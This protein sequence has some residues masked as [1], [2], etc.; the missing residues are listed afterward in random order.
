[1][2]S[3]GEKHEPQPIPDRSVQAVRHMR[4]F[5]KVMLSLDE[6]SPESGVG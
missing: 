6:V 5:V 4:R 3:A 1:M 2:I